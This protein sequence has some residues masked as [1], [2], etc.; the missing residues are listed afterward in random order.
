MD[1]RRR[2][3]RSFL[4]YSASTWFVGVLLAFVATWWYHACCMAPYHDAALADA[5]ALA[6]QIS[7]ARQQELRLFDTIQ[8][9][10]WA[11][12]CNS[13]GSCNQLVVQHTR[14]S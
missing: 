13:M 4:S 2:T 12:Y 6:A 10:G 9:G 1:E 11:A 8:G 7:P 3:D 14:P 5:E